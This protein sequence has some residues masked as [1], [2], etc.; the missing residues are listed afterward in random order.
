ML[1]K[2]NVECLKGYKRIYIIFY[3]YKY[4]ITFFQQTYQVVV[5]RYKGHDMNNYAMILHTYQPSCE[6]FAQI[7]KTE[8]EPYMCMYVYVYIGILYSAPENV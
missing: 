2:G 7:F 3:L 6:H 4:V 8:A 5:G 1:N